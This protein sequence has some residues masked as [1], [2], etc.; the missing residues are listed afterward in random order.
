[1]R[2]LST[3]LMVCGLTLTA[4][5]TATPRMARSPIIGGT[6]WKKSPLAQISLT[7]AQERNRRKLQRAL[8]T[9]K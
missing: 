3:L 6:G 1:M 5:A 8:D 2:T 9:L 4:G 7:P